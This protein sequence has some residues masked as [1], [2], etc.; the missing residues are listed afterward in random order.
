M[1]DYRGE[2]N[3]YQISQQGPPEPDMD[4]VA[5]TN[6]GITIRRPISMKIS[7]FGALAIGARK[8][9]SVDYTRTYETFM[10]KDTLA[11][12]NVITADGGAG[13][14]GGLRSMVL[15]LN[16]YVWGSTVKKVRDDQFFRMN[17]DANDG[18]GVDKPSFDVGDTDLVKADNMVAG[19]NYPTEGWR[20]FGHKYDK[21]IPYDGVL[22]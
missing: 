13:G 14:R 12:F 3:F 16:P 19:K 11:D 4:A 6:T 22:R 21:P 9:Q 1:A 17:M 10:E 18:S 15:D 8:D 5:R 20:S 7:N 2:W